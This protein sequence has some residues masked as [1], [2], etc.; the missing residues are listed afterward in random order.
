MESEPVHIDQSESVL[1]KEESK[2]E[3]AETEN[4]ENKAEQNEDINHQVT[5]SKTLPNPDGFFADT[6]SE[7]RSLTFISQEFLLSKSSCK[8]TA[9]ARERT[10]W[11]SKYLRRVPWYT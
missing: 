7:V 8:S 5:A 10:D 4:Q 2:V 11:K 6:K 3:T 9:V 1:E